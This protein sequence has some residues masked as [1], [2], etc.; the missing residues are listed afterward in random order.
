MPDTGH[1]GSGEPP[2]CSSSVAP[3][4]VGQL[5]WAAGHL[6]G[7]WC[8]PVGIQ[9]SRR[10]GRPCS[11]S[12]AGTATWRERRRLGTEEKV[13]PS[14][15]RRGPTGVSAGDARLK[16]WDLG[17]VQGMGKVKEGCYWVPGRQEKA[18]SYAEQEDHVNPS[19]GSAGGHWEEQQGT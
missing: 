16:N 6:W 5:W 12:A 9:G 3:H 14:F 18:G 10:A 11:S 2:D 15:R 19:Q 1:P 13:A 8:F 4:P 7:P 17:R